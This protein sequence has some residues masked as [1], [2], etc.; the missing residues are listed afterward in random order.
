MDVGSTQTASQKPLYLLSLD[1]NCNSLRTCLAAVKPGTHWRQSRLLPKPAT[2]RRQCRLSPIRSILSPVLAT[3]RQQLEFDS[4]SRSTLSPT[5]ST[6]LPIR[7]TLSPECRT[8]F[9]LCR[10]C[11]CTRPKRHGRLCRLSTK[12]TVL[13]STLSPVCTGLNSQSRAVY[14][15]SLALSA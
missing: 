7:S 5:R 6:L 15:T 3:N 11:M 12:S 8:S 4:L 13:K 9:R 14:G 10:Q 1:C 2:N